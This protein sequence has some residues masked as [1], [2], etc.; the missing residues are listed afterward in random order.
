MTENGM[1]PPFGASTAD[2]VCIGCG[3]TEHQACSDEAAG[4]P[5][6]WIRLDPAA[7]VGLCSVCDDLA[8]AWDAGDRRVRV[9]LDA[10]LPGF[11]DVH[12]RDLRDRPVLAP[13][14]TPR[15][16][17]TPALDAGRAFIRQ[18]GGC[19]LLVYVPWPPARQVL[20]GC[21]ACGGRQWWPQEPPVGPFADPETA[22]TDTEDAA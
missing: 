13:E 9:P 16:R 11:S 8:A 21:P 1:A 17:P 14:T 4:S 20:G 3:C 15:L 5:C 12:L 2:P 10:L 7:G 19:G 22:G 18:C 6:A